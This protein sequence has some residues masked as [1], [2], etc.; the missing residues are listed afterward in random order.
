[1]YCIILSLI[2]SIDLRLLDKMCT[3]APPH[4]CINRQNFEIDCFFV[5]A[6]IHCE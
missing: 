5:A 4:G 2:A 6:N 1:M 3:E